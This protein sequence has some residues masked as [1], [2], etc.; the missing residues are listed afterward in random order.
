MTSTLSDSIEPSTFKVKIGANAVMKSTKPCGS[1][2]EIIVRLDV[3]AR[4]VVDVSP[5]INVAVS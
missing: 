1:D 2:T 4:D 5:I 3:R